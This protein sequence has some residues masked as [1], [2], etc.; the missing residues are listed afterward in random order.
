MCIA[1]F[2]G[3]LLQSKGTDIASA[4]DITLGKD[5]NFWDITGTTTINRIASGGWE[6]GSEFKLQFDD[7]LTVAD[8]VASGSG[9]ASILISG[10]TNYTSAAGSILSCV[11][12][13]AV[14]KCSPFFDE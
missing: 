10:S 11:Y 6:A 13:G 12:D 3:R 4:N 5:G 8:N 7:A 14:F 1:Q 2:Y 9:F